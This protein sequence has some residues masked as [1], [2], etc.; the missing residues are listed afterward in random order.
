ML[1]VDGLAIGAGYG[2]KATGEQSASVPGGDD[3]HLTI[4]ANYSMGPVTFGVQL[5]ETSFLFP[6][7]F[8]EPIV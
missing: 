6:A 1:G 4:F 7:I 2:E 8:I 5:S 3:E